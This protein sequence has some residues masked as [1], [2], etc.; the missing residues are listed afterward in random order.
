M[1]PAA[2]SSR[3]QAELLGESDGSP[4]QRFQLLYS[5]VL[6]PTPAE[7]LEVLDPERGEWAKWEQRESFAESGPDDPHYVLDAADGT[8]ELGPAVRSPDG[9]WQQFGRVPPSRSLLRMTA[10]RDG[11]GRRGNVAAGTLTRA[12][13]G[14]SRRRPRSPT[15]SARP[16]A[17]TSRRSRARA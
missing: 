16:A 7:H 9:S 5:P 2:H 8:I 13:V 6:E 3:H 10:Y 14:D 1:I 4:A 17:S 11:G 12:E 15:R